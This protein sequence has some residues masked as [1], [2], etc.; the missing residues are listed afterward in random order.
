VAF[1]QQLVHV[2]TQAI[3]EGAQS[4]GYI[5][6]TIPETILDITLR[7]HLDLR[8]QRWRAGPASGLGGWN[9]AGRQFHR[10]LD[11]AVSGLFLLAAAG[12]GRLAA[13]R[14]RNGRQ[15]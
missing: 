7:H 4:A 1:L 2:F 14:K 12:V 8:S 9:V 13:R 5:Q 11:R 15:L 3:F 10:P 6:M